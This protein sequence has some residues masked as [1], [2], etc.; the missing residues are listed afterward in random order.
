MS[1]Y[2]IEDE[3]AWRCLERVR[4]EANCCCWMD[5]AE[6]GKYRRGIESAVKP[7]ARYSLTLNSMGFIEHFQ[8][9]SKRRVSAK[10]RNTR[11]R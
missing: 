7:Q 1:S 8:V 6:I 11:R 3:A 10:A 5:D 2:R 4:R 9:T